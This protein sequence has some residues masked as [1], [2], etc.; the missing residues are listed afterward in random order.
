MQSVI[1]IFTAGD[2][3]VGGCVVV[4]GSKSA[5][6]FPVQG[7]VGADV[8]PERAKIRVVDVV[9]EPGALERRFDLRRATLDGQHASNGELSLFLSEQLSNGCHEI[10]CALLLGPAWCRSYLS[11]G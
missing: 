6:P 2:P 11:I 9:K 3:S 5:F 8:G 1:D 10:V 7:A 4:V